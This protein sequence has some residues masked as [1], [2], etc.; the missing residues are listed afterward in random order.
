MGDVGEEIQ[1]AFIEFLDGLYLLASIVEF[2]DN[3]DYGQPKQNPKDDCPPSCI[4]R[5]K[6]AQL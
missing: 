2:Y 1:L 3:G 6:D 5:R 4:P